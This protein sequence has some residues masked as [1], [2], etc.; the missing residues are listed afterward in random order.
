V[1]EAVNSTQGHNYS[2]IDSRIVEGFY[3]ADGKELR[4]KLQ[5]IDH[6][7]HAEPGASIEL[8]TDFDNTLTIG[9]GAWESLH[10]ALPLEGRRE[11]Q[12]ERAKNLALQALGSLPPAEVLAWTERELAR[13]A[14][15]H[16]HTS[17]IANGARRIKVRGGARELFAFCAEHSVKRRVISASVTNVIEHTAQLNKL[18][19]EREDIIANTLHYGSDGTVTHW[20]AEAMVHTRNKYDRIEERHPPVHG[21]KRCIVVLGD[22]LDDAH[23][24]KDTQ[25]DIVLRI[26][27]APKKDNLQTYLA[28]SWHEDQA[29][30][31]KHFDLVLRH[32]ELFAVR[33]LMELLTSSVR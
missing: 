18:I 3:I 17:A 23:M 27:T 21:Q 1:L 31:R 22:S 20:D 12:E 16:T 4:T 13:H 33:D 15:H 10:Y 28:E 25:N 26:R 30:H 11:S 6:A 14:K 7:L 9:K 29:Q 5:V 2:G 32:P 19:V 8:R 24:A